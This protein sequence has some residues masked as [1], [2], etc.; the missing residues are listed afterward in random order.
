MGI[1]LLTALIIQ[2]NGADVAVGIDERN[3][4]YGFEIYGIIR[5]KYRAHLTSE[6]LY[7]SEEIAEIEGRKTLDSILSL[8]LRKKRKEL[9]EILGEEKEMIGKIIEASEE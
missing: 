3:G 6:G 9:N 5:E 7:D 8:D 1:Y 4:K 2:E